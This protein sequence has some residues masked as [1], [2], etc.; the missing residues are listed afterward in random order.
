MTSFFSD[1]EVRGLGLGSVGK[2]V[3]ISRHCSIY[4]K[5]NIHIG[6]NVRIDDFSILSGN[7]VLG[8]YVHIAAGVY[9]YAGVSKIIIND[10]AG[11]SA[12]SIIYAISDDF[13][14]GYLTN[15]MVPDEY[16]NVKQGE[17]VL[18][19]HVVVGAHT[20][21][22]PNVVIGEGSTVGSMSLVIKSLDPW[23]VYVGIP[24]RRIK[25]RDMNRTLMN[26]KQLSG[27]KGLL[28][29]I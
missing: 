20:V 9:L 16:R 29:E 10:F 18:G 21:I 25:D 14:G 22:L 8:D 24:C 17:V 15:P 4:S 13:V 28:E 26:E 27:E 3:L 2:N 12:Q 19:R 5:A 7:I 11:V 23:G 1:E 6:N